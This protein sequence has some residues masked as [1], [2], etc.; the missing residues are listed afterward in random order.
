MIVRIAELDIDPGQLAAYRQLL[1]E[2]IEASMRLEPGVL[3]LHAVA[4][5]GN[6]EKVRLLEGYADQAAYEAHLT[7]PHFLKYK[8]AAANKVRSLRLIEAEPISL[9]AKPSLRGA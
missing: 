2:E 6:P 4:L 5:K 1:E 8:A 7:T 9:A 3:F